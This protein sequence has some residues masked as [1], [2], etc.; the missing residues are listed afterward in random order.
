MNILSA[1]TPRRMFIW[2]FLVPVLISAGY[3]AVL[4]KSRYVSQAIVAVRD[5]SAGG[6][7]SSA[8]SALSLASMLGSVNPVAISDTLYLMAYLHSSD[9]IDKLEAKLQIRDH[10]AAGGLDVFYRVWPWMSKEYFHEYFR[11]RVTINLD[12]MS[13]LLTV[14]VEGF[15]PAFSKKIADEMLVQGEAF[16]NDYAHRIASDKVEFAR[17]ETEKSLQR[18]LEAKAKI[19]DFQ[20]TH[21]LLDPTSQAVANSTLT[22]SLQAGLTQ[23][24]AALKAA[25]GYL[26]DDS[27]QVQTMKNQINALKAQLEVERVRATAGTGVDKL[28]A[29][30][31]EYQSLLTLGAFYDGT[32]QASMVA[33]EQA[34]L[35]SLRKLKTVVVLQKPSTAESAIYPSRLY[36]FT[37]VLILLGLL[38]SIFRLAVATI[39]EHQD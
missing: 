22:A 5:T 37:T 34:R 9:M 7:A 29:L 12:E 30:S 16:M 11:R 39:R 19:V 23:Q 36:N 28:G 35:D 8:S 25:L 1:L 21:K 33:L 2:L 10:F 3:F 27:L 4:A 26:Q 38:Y 18:A 13:G 24:E 32:Y 20:T 31:F 14:D 17:K 6:P 15:D